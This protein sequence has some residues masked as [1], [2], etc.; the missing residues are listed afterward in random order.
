MANLSLLWLVHFAHSVMH[1]SVHNFRVVSLRFRWTNRPGD[2]WF[3]C[4]SKLERGK[5]HGTPVTSVAGVYS[6]MGSVFPSLRA[7]R[8]QPRSIR[9]A[10]GSLLKFAIERR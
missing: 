2:V 5:K 7:P 3:S 4:A 8:R 9:T 10:R 1:R 6:F